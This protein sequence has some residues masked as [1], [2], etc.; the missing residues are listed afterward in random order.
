MTLRIF[1][2]DY[3]NNFSQD[4]D[5]IFTVHIE[6]ICEKYTPLNLVDLAK[7]SITESVRIDD[8]LIL[9]LT[10]YYTSQA[11]HT[12]PTDC[13]LGYR[14]VSPTSTFITPTSTGL[15]VFTSDWTNMKLWT[16]TIEFY[17]LNHNSTRT[18]GTL[19]LSLNVTANCRRPIT[20]TANSLPKDKS[21]L[22]NHIGA[23]GYY[24]LSATSE[25][26][27]MAPFD[28]KLFYW[29]T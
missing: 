12:T 18:Y 4:F 20:W 13:M 26:T 10:N 27:I 11:L 6:S 23:E 28:C 3:P 1:Y 25:S 14:V 16:H 24:T 17:F 8:T 29:V 5:Y 2:A 9:D 15:S 22:I 19:P 7:S 21:S